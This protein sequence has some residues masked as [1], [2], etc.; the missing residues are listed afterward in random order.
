L[1]FS[2]HLLDLS[3]S[4][5][6]DVANLRITNMPAKKW[7]FALVFFCSV[8]TLRLAAQVNTSTT[9]I[10]EAVN[11]GKVVVLSATVHPLAR[12]QYD[13]GVAPASLPMNHMLLVL[14]RSPQQQA[15]L[16]SLLAEQQDQSSP[17]YHKWLTPAQFGAE[18]GPS[19]QDVQTI[20]AWLESQGF[21]V[22]SV[23]AGRTVVDFS[24]SAATVQSAFHTAI[25]RYVLPNGKEHW[26]NSTNIE[27]P[28][29][30]T[31]VVAGVRSLN[32]FFPKPQYHSAVH[33][34]FTFAY[35]TQC[36]PI[37]SNNCFDV[38]PADFA[39]I[40]DIP[41]GA[42]GAGETI[43]IV[44]NSDVVASD[45]TQF[46]SLFGIQ[47]ITLN[48]SGNPTSTAPS[49]AS[50]PC[51][52]QFV[53]PG[54]T[55]PGVLPSGNESE[56]ALDVEWAGA[57]APA[58]N[59]WLVSSADSGATFGGDLSA[60]YV[61]NCDSLNP[62]YSAQCT[63]P[64][65]VPVPAHVLSDSYGNCESAL[66]LAGNTF[67][68]STWSQ[69]A[70]EGI[71][72]V[73]ATL[74]SGSA[75]CDF[76]D[77]IAG[78]PQP[79][80]GGLAVDGTASTPDDTAVGGTDFDQAS[81]PTQFWSTTN[82][83][84]GESALGYIPETTWNDSCTNA[85]FGSDP[86]GDCNNASNSGF[87]F[88][89]GGGGGPSS[90]A[91]FS[92]S[93][94]SAGYPK[95]SWQTALTPADN[96]RDT[97]D[98]ALFASNG[99]VGSAY[100]M[101]EADSPAPGQNGTACSLAS[102]PVNGVTAESYEEVGGTSVAA[103]AFAGIAALIDEQAGGGGQGRMNDN[104]YAIAGQAGSTCT[105]AAS[106]AST[107]VFY[108]VTSGTTSQ[109]CAYGGS[110]SPNCIGASSSDAYGALGSGTSSSFTPSYNAAAGYDYATG[111]GS[112]NVAN[113]ICAWPVATPGGT[114]TSLQASLSTITS[115]QSVTFTATVA[116]SAGSC[117][118]TGTVNFLDGSTVIG[119]GTLNGSGVA[120]FG[121]TSLAVGAHSITAVYQAS[122]DFATS[123]SSAA[124]VQV[125]ALP[126]DF[127][128]SASPSSQSVTP[129]QP[130][131]YTLTLTPQNGFNQA[132]T[133]SCSGVPTESTCSAATSP[134]TLN[135]TTAQQ[136][137]IN[138]TTTAASF[139]PPAS[140]PFS[141]W[142]APALLASF[143]LL[144]WLIADRFARNS[145]VIRR[146]LAGAACV[147]AIVFVL[148][149]CGGGNKS[150]PPP[151]NNGTPAGTSTLT[152]TGT[153]G[154]T[155]HTATVSLVVQ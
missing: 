46:R 94:C 147:T 143:M 59:I 84:T 9:R 148:V 119:S 13:R 8:S 151:T 107:C 137:T 69:A 32:N 72:V 130:T 142:R 132:V 6:G 88:T 86:I 55:D 19:D 60:T 78:P 56:A 95:P 76:Y 97:P 117:V 65:A 139:A 10:A 77:Q 121:T 15:A 63:V 154:S 22:N 61:V 17:N 33:P 106:P 155:S 18:F 135:G 83:G 134:V 26:A 93:N 51:F 54:Q 141:G 48:S 1:Y 43:A 14:K 133:V 109:P 12:P 153:S 2:P 104:L 150:T 128:V 122:S 114:T 110:P 91:T 68:S 124:Q 24:G 140:V 38:T 47:S 80:M 3:V 20:T 5:I 7:F 16:D 125:N 116:Q 126:P 41:A 37:N 102:P 67:Y 81:N 89:L 112:V 66:G 39:K 23:S 111:L 64:G 29:A 45:L 74:D 21:T 44:S 42:T 115:G 34:A 58:A 85:L 27:I 108:D 57:T 75:G 131:S 98:I 31:P 36:G 25:H 99:F 73:A 82:S 71:T 40:Y 145:M 144:C 92:G 49:C 118:P 96:V 113:L 30:L 152:I 35:G 105:S 87:V 120:T 149:G 129:G 79:A 52:V 53:P 103:Q 100:I 62:N 123:T 4:S 138:V 11:N 28:A 50:S 146:C 90:C 101:C 127:S 70:A 136:V